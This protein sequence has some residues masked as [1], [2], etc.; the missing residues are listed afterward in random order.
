MNSYQSNFLSIPHPKVGDFPSFFKT[1]F[2]ISVKTEQK[3]HHTA[4]LFGFC[5]EGLF[6]GFRADFSTISY[7]FSHFLIKSV[8]IS[9]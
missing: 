3:R 8:I 6:W 7:Y 5:P 9:I 2:K 1:A 4:T